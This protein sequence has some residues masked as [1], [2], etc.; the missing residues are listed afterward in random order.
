LV[1]VS[2]NGQHR[3]GRFVSCLLLLLLLLPLTMMMMMMMI[4]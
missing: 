2:R 4:K 1:S 3:D